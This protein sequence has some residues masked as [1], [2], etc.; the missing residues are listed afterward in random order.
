PYS[1]AAN[2]LTGYSVN[3]RFNVVAYGAD[4]TGQADAAPAINAAVN[5]ACTFAATSFDNLAPTVF[6]PT[7]V[8]NI[9]SEPVLDA[10]AHHLKFEGV[11]QYGSVL[12]GGKTI[13]L[14][15]AYP[16]TMMAQFG[17]GLEA[18]PLVGS[19]GNSLVF[20][21]GIT[22]DYYN[23]GDVLHSISA[24]PLNGLSQFT[25]EAF[26]NAPSASPGGVWAS[27]G[28]LRDNPGDGDLTGFGYF[29]PGATTTCQL[30]VGGT[31]YKV[32]GTSAACGTANTT[33]WAAC[34]YDGSTIRVYTGVPGATA[35]LVA[36]QAATGT[37]VQRFDETMDLGGY[38]T[39]GWPDEGVTGIFTPYT[40]KVFSFRLSNT[41]RY[42]ATAPTTPNAELAGDG[43]T[44]LLI[45]GDV[46][47][48]SAG[49]IGADYVNGHAWNPPSNVY[50]LVIRGGSSID[51]GSAPSISHL[52]FFGGA[53]GIFVIGEPGALIDHVNLF[54]Q[55]HAGIL[56]Y[57][58]SYEDILSNIIENNSG[59]VGIEGDIVSQYYVNNAKIIGGYA[60]LVAPWHAAYT[61]W[62]PSDTPGVGIL[63]R[64]PDIADENTCVTC[65]LDTENGGS[66][67]PFV[68]VGIGGGDT[69]VSP[70]MQTNASA[71]VEGMDI[72]GP[73]AVTI[74]GGE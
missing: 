69:L 44:L 17:A 28:A 7:G 64:N 18:A 42:G 38:P 39:Q 33:C 60:G 48:P 14:I 20:G 53:D 74:T 34:S 67:V 41:A 23:L 19:S 35:T 10:C 26:I 51:Q 59:V 36:S 71:N 55:S 73:V 16:S 56:L 22:G 25:V 50:D 61:E 5:A 47:N 9:A 12:K 46:G 65:D 13:P 58:N 3:G 72:E 27:G 62:S 30:D 49:L 40:G 1:A 32:Q 29:Q 54:A 31:V 68:V 63:F 8:Y 21:T 24:T 57:S 70:N 4:P 11:S 15:L 52:N 2:P 37:L 66:A 43:D 45:N 6:F